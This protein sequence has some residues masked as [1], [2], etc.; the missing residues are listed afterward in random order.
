MFNFFKSDSDKKTRSLIAVVKCSQVQIKTTNNGF[1]RA[2]GYGQCGNPRNCQVSPDFKYVV[3]TTDK[4][5]ICISETA[6]GGIK[7]TFNKGSFGT[8]GYPI[9][10]SWIDNETVLV[11]TDKGNTY[12]IKIATGGARKLN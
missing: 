12:S 1:I 3:A 9:S 11:N 4:G 5:Y 10:A 8:G 6:V 2:I 7:R